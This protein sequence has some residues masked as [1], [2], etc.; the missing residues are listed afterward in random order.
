[1]SMYK[2]PSVNS[3]YARPYMNHHLCFQDRLRK[4]FYGSVP[5]ELISQVDAPLKEASR[6]KFGLPPVG[7]APDLM[8]KQDRFPKGSFNRMNNDSSGFSRSFG[9][10]GWSGSGGLNSLHRTYFG[11][12]HRPEDVVEDFRHPLLSQKLERMRASSVPRG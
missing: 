3:P 12:V 9:F 6:A 2:Q 10:G 8:L 4:E 5:K 1:M 7:S 11:P